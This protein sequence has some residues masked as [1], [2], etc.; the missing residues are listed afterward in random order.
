MRRAYSA[1]ASSAQPGNLA[2]TAR[3][4]SL[5]TRLLR[6]LRGLPPVDKVHRLAA[7]DF[8]EIV[9]LAHRGMHDVHDHVAEV[10]EYPVAHVLALYSVHARAELADPFLHPV[11]QR[12]DLPIG[13][14]ARNHHALEHRGHARGVV[15]DDVAALHVLERFDHGA[16]LGADIHQE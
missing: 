6:F 7:P 2:L 1:Q 8:L 16:L 10:D 5:G 4:L 9:E 3:T 14:A 12:S 15:D 11:C 13:V